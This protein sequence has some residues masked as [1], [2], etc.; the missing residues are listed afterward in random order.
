MPNLVAIAIAFAAGVVS[1]LS[2]CVLPLIPAYLSF[3]TGLTAAE[4][5][6]ED[7]RTARVLDSGVA[8]RRRLLGGVRCA[9]R[10]RVGARRLPL[11]V[12]GRHREGRRRRG[13]RVWRADARDHQGPVAVRRSA[14]GHGEVPQLRQGRRVRDGHVVRRG[15]DAVRGPDP[16]V[17]PGVG[18]FQRQRRPGCRTAAGVLARAGSAVHPRCR[19]LQPRH[20]A[21]CAG[22]VATRS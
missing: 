15:V 16:G 9:R 19:A 13:D 6:Q 5:A 14:G 4:L 7:R 8:V 20:A 22:S 12:P 1:F 3:M 18:G 21:S 17:H 10:N 11:G 2:P